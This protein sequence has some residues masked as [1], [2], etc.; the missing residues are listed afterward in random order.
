MYLCSWIC[1]RRRRSS[2]ISRR[3]RATELPR[4]SPPPPPA[5]TTQCSRRRV[6]SR[7]LAES[8]V[9]D[10]AA[11]YELNQVREH[12]RRKAPIA[13]AGYSPEPGVLDVDEFGHTRMDA[14]A[15]TAQWFQRHPAARHR[16]AST[17]AATP[18]RQRL[19]SGHTCVLGPKLEP[20]PRDARVA[21]QHPAVE[22]IGGVAIL[23]AQGSPVRR[24]NTGDSLRLQLA[25]Q[26]V[27]NLGDLRRV[28]A[29]AL[30]ARD[31]LL[32]GVG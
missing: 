20:Y 28:T 14:R 11:D 22:G 7:S 2:S 19:A 5:K 32:G 10:A 12:S 16:T 9:V 3:A 4:D 6:S 17:A 8:I 23:A 25:L 26:G 29:C 24:T 31:A 15:R 13:V 30:A 21:S 1:R 27:E 18:L